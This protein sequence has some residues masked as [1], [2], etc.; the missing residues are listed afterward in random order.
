[1]ALVG[2][3]KYV[4]VHIN[5]KKTFYRRSQVSKSSNRRHRRPADAQWEKKWKTVSDAAESSSVFR[6]AL[7]VV[8]NWLIDWWW[9]N[10]RNW[11]HTY[12]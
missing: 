4:N 5:V 1:M 3:G 8:M 10:F 2:S 6:C 7:K 9:R 11:R 12:I